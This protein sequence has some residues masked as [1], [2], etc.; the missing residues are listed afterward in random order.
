MTLNF[1]KTV[2]KIGTD[3]I[4]N[5]RRHLSLEVMSRIARDISQIVN[6]TNQRIALVSSGAVAAGRMELNG[7]RLEINPENLSGTNI[8]LE[9]K[10]ILAS[11]GQGTLMTYWK[12]SFGEQGQIPAGELLTTYRTFE[13]ETETENFRRLLENFFR[14]NI[15]PI[16]N[17]NDALTVEPLK[18]GDNDFNA[19]EVARTINA[20]RLILCT[21]VDGLFDSNPNENPDA[22]LIKNLPAEKITDELIEKLCKG[23]SKGGTG[24]MRSKLE[25]A[26]RIAEYGIE[27]QIINGGREGKLLQTLKNEDHIGT[28]IVF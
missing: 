24:G 25:V 23:K 15:I 26:R 22:K 8:Q 9:R 10:R 18:T 13:E 7:R 1:E 12:K 2:V 11:I 16:I 20:N 28:K 5:S 19:G 14:N 4:T 6:S 27:T 21:N 3:T 17:A